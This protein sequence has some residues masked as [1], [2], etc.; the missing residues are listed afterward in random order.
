MLKA[1][2]LPSPIINALSSSNLG[3]SK[4]K[5]DTQTF[6]ELRSGLLI[7]S[8]LIMNIDFIVLLD[9][10]HVRI[11]FSVDGT[12]PDPFQVFKTG[13]V[14]TYLYRGAFRLGPGRR[15]VKAI[16]VTTYIKIVS[17]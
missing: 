11:Y 14:S 16:A 12:K 1:G 15:V 7:E 9:I 6:V 10:P 2:L 13:H 17:F 5:I 8:C 4:N 3:S